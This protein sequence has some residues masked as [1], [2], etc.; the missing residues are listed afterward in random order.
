MKSYTDTFASTVTDLNRV[1]WPC[2]SEEVKKSQEFSFWKT[3]QICSLSSESPGFFT[4]PRVLGSITS[5]CS[6]Y[7]LALLLLKFLLGRIEDPVPRKWYKSSLAG[8]FH[9]VYGIWSGSEWLEKQLSQ[10]YVFLVCSGDDKINLAGGPTKFVTDVS[11]NDKGK[12]VWSG[13]AT[14]KVNCEMKVDQWPFDEQTCELAFGSFSY[15]KNLLRLKL[16]KSERR[17]TSKIRSL[18]RIKVSLWTTSHQPL[19]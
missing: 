3:S 4:S 17:F 5:P 19:P 2:Q 1:P 9:N 16:F 8:C 12:C 10:I 15:G 13:P 14:F 6:R 18:F 7:E 11:V